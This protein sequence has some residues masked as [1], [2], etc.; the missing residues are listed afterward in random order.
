ML[1]INT[2]DGG[3]LAVAGF[4]LFAGCAERSPSQFAALAEEPL[5]AGVGL[6]Q[7]KLMQTTLGSFTR[8]FGLAESVVTTDETSARIDFVKEG[9][10]FLFGG[11]PACAQALSERMSSASEPPDINAFLLQNPGCETMLLE[12]IAAYIPE[13]NEPLYEGETLEGV[14]LN[15]AREMAER[16]Y[17]ATQDAVNALESGTPLPEQPPQAPD[18]LR[19]PGL[20]IYLGRD[21]DGREVVRKL[22]V[23]PREY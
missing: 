21:P 22:E 18:E 19:Y 23:I 5:Q 13:Q 3:R 11:D 8:K 1:G 14:G 12:S 17:R 15:A 7:L 4:L 20:R 9:L 2:A 16:A 10:T 6:G